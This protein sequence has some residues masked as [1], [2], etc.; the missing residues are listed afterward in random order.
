V[1]GK[2]TLVNLLSRLYDPTSGQVVVD[3]VDIKE[4]K[5]PHFRRS[6]AVLTQEHRLFPGLSLKE[7]IGLGDIERSDNEERIM[8]SVRKGGAERVIGKLEEGVET[9]LDS[10]VR[11]Q[12]YLVDEED[13]GNPLVVKN[14]QLQKASSVSG[15]SLRSHTTN[16]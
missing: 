8:E 10:R 6:V 2:S 1:S 5:L 11:R 13:E 12:A 15:A 4:Y 3:G 14:K 16:L 9:V 7:N